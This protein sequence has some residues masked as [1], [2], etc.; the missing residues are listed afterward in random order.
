MFTCTSPAS[1]GAAV[2]AP[3]DIKCKGRVDNSRS[4]KMTQVL[5]S[6]SPEGCRQSPLL[7][8]LPRFPQILKLSQQ[9]PRV[10][11]THAVAALSGCPLFRGPTWT[12]CPQRGGS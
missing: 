1:Q 6:G 3:R 8:R 9:T 7:T 5:H 11:I 4:C 2:Q 10:P 12:V